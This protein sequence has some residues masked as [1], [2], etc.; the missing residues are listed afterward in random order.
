MELDIDPK[1]AT[2][3]INAAYKP[4]VLPLVTTKSGLYNC[5]QE[6]ICE[7][8]P[9]VIE[10]TEADKETVSVKPTAYEIKFLY[11]GGDQ[12]QVAK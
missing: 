1:I 9:D 5:T 12:F 7:A 11:L 3:I 6:Y 8:Q 2:K 4:Y 10:Q